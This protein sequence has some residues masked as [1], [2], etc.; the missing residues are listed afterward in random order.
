M[1]DGTL[2][3]ARRRAPVGL[4]LR[5]RE[6]AVL[7]HGR[8]V[9]RL[10]R[11]HRRP[12]RPDRR[13]PGGDRPARQHDHLLLRRQRRVRRGQP[14]RLGQREQVL[15]R[16]ART[17]SR[18]TCSISTSSAARTPTTTIPTGWAVAF[19]TP[20]Q[21]FK[22]Y[23]LPGRHLR[24]AGDPL[25]EGHQGQG[26]GARPVPPRDRHRADD[27]RLLRAR[28]PRDP[29]RR[30]SSSRCPAS[31]CATPSTTPT[32][33]RPR[34]AS[35]TRCSARAASGRTAGRPSPCT[36]RPPGIGHFDEDVWQL[37]HT[38]EDRAEAH[39][40]AEQHPEKLKQLIDAW[41]E[42]AEKYHVLP[43]DDR[44]PPRSSPTRGRS[45]SPT[46]TRSSTTRTP[47]T[48]R[49]GR[50][51]HPRPLVQDPRRRRAHEPRRERRDLR[52]RLALR[53]PRAVHQGPEALLRLQL[54]RHP[55]GAA[56]RLRRRSSPAST[57]SAWSSPKERT[58]EHGESHRHDEA[59][60]R[61]QGRWRTGR[62]AR[63]RHSSRSA[64]T[65]SAS[66]ATAPT[67]SARST[68]RP[69]RSRAGRSCQVEVN[70]G[71]DQYLDL[72]KQAAAMM[73]RE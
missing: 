24:P 42:E 13:L 43:L 27:P 60:R 56:V 35:T 73:A 68:R 47:P 50:R 30:T 29:E 6:E 14:E 59:L 2:L 11:V 71:D 15:Q 49:V 28:V 65:A 32:P 25:A 64:A 54:P 40:L 55:A 46:A 57:C 45:P 22:R 33:R 34:S 39:D 7:A 38:D 23:S 72:E 18:R 21:M 37:F 44:R 20:F 26:R 67:P 1:P 36:G 8:G 4:A 31:R 52:P 58:G 3:A 70:V 41:F 9:R 62:C 16:L 12:G 10:L 5:R 53:R 69:A 61:R 51:Q 66:A 63:S 48:C 17:R 19:S